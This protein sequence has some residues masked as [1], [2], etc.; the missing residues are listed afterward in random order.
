VR[1]TNG[2]SPR[3]CRKLLHGLDATLLGQ[4]SQRLR[5]EGGYGA[6]GAGQKGGQGRGGGGGVSRLS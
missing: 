4:H 5:S 6:G 1:A 2:A 3:C